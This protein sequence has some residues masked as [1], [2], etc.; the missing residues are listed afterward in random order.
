MPLLPVWLAGVQRAAGSL[1]PGCGRAMK[2]K[3]LET[4]QAP[5]GRTLHPKFWELLQKFGM[6]LYFHFKIHEKSID[7]VAQLWHII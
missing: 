2:K 1:L 4:P 3:P 5:A 6:T 7:N